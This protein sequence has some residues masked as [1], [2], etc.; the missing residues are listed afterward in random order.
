[1]PYIAR[2]DIPYA[3]G[4]LSRFT[5]NPDLMYW[6][7]ISRVLKYL[8]KTMHYGLNYLGYPS[9]L[10]GYCDASRKVGPDNF[11]S[12]RMVG[13]TLLVGPQFLGGFKKKTCITHF[14]MEWEFVALVAG[15]EEAEWLRNL[16]LEIPI[17]LRPMPPISLHCDSTSTLSWVYTC[18][19]VSPGILD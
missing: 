3:V 11:M 15:G 18:T 6:N 5:G 13:Y 14:T 12:P 7:V 8:K 2:T 17:W 9:V 16:L 19:M 10:E 4:K 1:M